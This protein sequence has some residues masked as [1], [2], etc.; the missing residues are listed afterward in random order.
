MTNTP[1]TSLQLTDPNLVAGQDSKRVMVQIS[2]GIL[3]PLYANEPVE[4]F[5]LGMGQKILSA[6]KLDN[7]ARDLIRLYE[8]GGYVDVL[9]EI[10]RINAPQELLLALL[11]R[12]R[13]ERS[14]IA[15]MNAKSKLQKNCLEQL[16]MEATKSYLSPRNRKKKDDFAHEFHQ[17]LETRKNEAVRKLSEAKRL[18]EEENVRHTDGGAQFRKRP[19]NIRKLNEL[20]A[21]VEAAKAQV[22]FKVYAPTT[23][24]DVWLKGL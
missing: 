18:L 16:R 2:D 10:E 20:K 5:A 19:E 6:F 3:V 1:T 14:T 9:A 24:R 7:A 4:R 8:Q 23:I 22:N 11:L 21:V 12:R 13:E 17:K 15:R